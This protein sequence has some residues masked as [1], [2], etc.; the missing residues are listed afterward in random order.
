MERFY[1][2][3]KIVAR[4]RKLPL[5][6]MAVALALLMPAIASVPVFGTPFLRMQ[7]E[8]QL[9][10]V[11]EEWSNGFYDGMT[12]EEEEPFKELRAA[13][14]EAVFSQSDAVFYSSM[15]R[16]NAV[17]RDL[18][19]QGALVSS[20]GLLEGYQLFYEAMAQAGG[21]LSFDVASKMPAFEY[22]SYVFGTTPAI[23]LC[24]PVLTCAAV[25]VGSYRQGIVS[26]QA[27]RP[28]LNLFVCTF[29]PWALSVVS[30]I[31][32]FLPAMVWMAACNGLGDLSYPIAFMQGDQAIS[33]TVGESLFVSA[34]LVLLGSLCLSALMALLGMWSSVFVGCLVAG[35]IGL[36]PNIGL[37]GGAVP[38]DIL[39]LCVSTYLA[40]G[41]LC[42]YAGCF[43]AADSVLSEALSPFPLC[44]VAFALLIVAASLVG[45]AA[46]ALRRVYRLWLT[47]RWTHA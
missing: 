44:F 14:K 23:I 39:A 34:T 19:A 18:A 27:P 2:V 33:T 43:S 36:L 38:E 32:S 6:T 41:I 15:Q 40:P 10:Q 46:W 12:P 31:V 21:P 4:D 47:E 22:A 13:L 11:E 5:V 28:V 1:I 9:R 3:W 37:Y 20:A 7:A 25:A 16:A 45:A 42:G 30:L 26:L 29:A 17:E 35:A 24:M 8:N